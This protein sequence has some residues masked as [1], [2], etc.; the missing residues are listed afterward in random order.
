MV[1]VERIAIHDSIEVIARSA[2]AS[3][4]YNACKG[5]TL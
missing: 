5:G 4:F 2:G 1:S 3:G